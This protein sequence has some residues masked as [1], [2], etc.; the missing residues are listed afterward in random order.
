MSHTKESK[1]SSALYSCSSRSC[2]ALVRA[3]PPSCLKQKKTK[4]S[5]V[6]I[7]RHSKNSFLWQLNPCIALLQ[8]LLNDFQVQVN[9]ILEYR[10]F[11]TG[12]F[13]K[14]WFLL[15][16]AFFSFGKLKLKTGYSMHYTE[17][18]P[19]ILITK[20]CRCRSHFYLNQ[21]KI[22]VVD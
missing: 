4:M 9:Y 11:A 19:V 14:K 3:V 15:N 2:A 7:L 12:S 13:C 18:R 22:N 21:H 6:V 16:P 5:M 17:Y 10:K 8:Y 20:Y 1:A